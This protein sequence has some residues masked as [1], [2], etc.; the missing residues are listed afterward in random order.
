MLNV[1]IHKIH[2]KYIIDKAHVL[3]MISSLQRMVRIELDKSNWYICVYN[4]YTRTEYFILSILCG[5]L[6][7]HFN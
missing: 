6:F 4:H 3:Q 7:I 5:I 1:L 2:K